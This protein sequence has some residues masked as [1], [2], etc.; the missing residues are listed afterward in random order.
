MTAIPS[1]T[2]PT[3]PCPIDGCPGTVS[4]MFVGFGEDALIWACDANGYHWWN[5]DGSPQ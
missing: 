1:I 2:P 5:E 4:A 3:I